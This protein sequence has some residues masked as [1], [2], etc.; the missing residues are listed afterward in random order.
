VTQRRK[1]ED[2]KGGLRG[3]KYLKAFLHVLDPLRRLP[4]HGNRELL[5][6]QYVSLLLLSC[7]NPLL[8]SLRSLQRATELEQVQ[9]AL[10]VKR[11]SLGSLSESAA[12]VF[13]PRFLEPILRDVGG[14]VGRATGQDL[15]PRLDDLSHAVLAAD[16]S[17]LRCLPGMTWALFRHQSAHRGV[18]LHVQVDVGRGSPVEA[19]LTPANAGERKELLKRLRSAVLYVMDR[20]YVDYSLYQAV[21]DAGS[22]F[23]ARL[24][25]HCACRVVGDRLRTAADIR[26]GVIADQWVEVGSAATDGKLT[27]RVRR[28]VVRP[29]GAPADG[30]KDVVLLTNST[31]LPAE[32]VALIY[33]WRWQVELFFK[34]LKCVLGCGGHWVSR[35]E[36]GLTIQ[37]YVALL[38]S[39]LLNL[40]TGARPSK[41]TFQMVCLYFQGWASEAEL[42]HHI[43]AIRPTAQGP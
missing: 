27:A 37:V 22:L 11:T 4:A 15:D 41:A 10:G 36:S 14:R 31:D 8:D 12:D 40:W 3:L 17:F 30:S 34:W 7:Y 16:G 28:L 25:A 39:M 13:D 18:K 26:A 38:A 19:S 43:D 23:V 21:H 42:A 5:Y 29:K 24:K 33:R 32:A 1:I 6:H 2:E 35:S 20:G 9:Q